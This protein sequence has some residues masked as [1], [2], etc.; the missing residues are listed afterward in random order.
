MGDAP[1]STSTPPAPN[2]AQPQGSTPPDPG[3]ALLLDLRAQ[4][5]VSNGKLLQATQQIKDLNAAADNT[6]AMSVSRSAELA[7]ARATIG[8]QS[9]KL[10][11]LAKQVLSLTD[12]NAKLVKQVE[13]LNTLIAGA[14]TAS[15]PTLPRNT[16]QLSESVTIAIVQNGKNVGMGAHAGD[17]LYVGNESDLGV[18]AVKYGEGGRRRVFVVEQSTVDE[19]NKLGFLYKNT[20]R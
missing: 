18:N 17:V 6:N 8:Q 16:Y 7:D 15:L 1:S 3:A 13:Q 5:E 14:N 12:E 2:A 11:E 10:D 20:A 4:L 9:G 19:L